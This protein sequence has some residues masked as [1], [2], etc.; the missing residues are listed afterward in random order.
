MDRLTIIIELPQLVTNIYME[1][2]VGPTC[3]ALT[4]RSGS[5]QGSVPPNSAINQL[6]VL[7][8]EFLGR[9]LHEVTRTNCTY[10]TLQIVM[11]ILENK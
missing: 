5:S 7:A 10:L 2:G 4:A 9:S 3:T 11:G 1:K 8:I 6:C